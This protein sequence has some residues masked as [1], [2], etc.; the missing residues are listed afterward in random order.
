MSSLAPARGD[1]FE[2]EVTDRGAATH[3][4]HGDRPCVIVQTDALASGPP[5]CVIVPTTK[6]LRRRF[7]P[8]CVFL[9]KEDTGLPYDS[10]ALTHQIRV[11]DRSHL[12]EFKGALASDLLVKLDEALRFT[13]G[14]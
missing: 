7:Q 9:P 12:K 13:L 3:V 5:T 4:Q 11:V 1:V 6:N 10:L 8:S 14:L 2:L